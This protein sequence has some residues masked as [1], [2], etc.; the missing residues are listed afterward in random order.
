MDS[1]VVGVCEGWGRF[2]IGGIRTGNGGL[3]VGMDEI[4]LICDLFLVVSVV[5]DVC[6]NMM[7]GVEDNL[8]GRRAHFW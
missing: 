2:L 4:V 8:G 7:E 6:G 1:D 5:I 3:S